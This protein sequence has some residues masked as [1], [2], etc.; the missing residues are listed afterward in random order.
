[1]TD[2][3]LFD[4]DGTLINSEAIILG[5]QMAVAE[6]FGLAFP[7]REAGLAIVG[8]SLPVALE[9]L[10]GTAAPVDA[11]CESYKL[12]FNGMR[13]RAGYEEPPF[14]GVPGLLAELGGWAGATVG[15][16]TGKTRKGVDA[17]VDMHGWHGVFRTIQTADSAPS[18]PDPGMI[19]QAAAET[20]GE[21][22][23]TVMIG[24]SVHDMAMARAAGATA[25]A[26]SWGF[27]PP[28]M[29]EAAGAHL[30][31][32]EVAELPGLIARALRR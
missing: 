7:G 29:L 18:K 24:D 28:A 19:L 21:P 30:V 25:I 16:A 11:L 13:G 14:A 2:L 17:V 10:F 32:R 3:I 8:L 4:L 23:R 5:A 15:M 12:A 31:A 20:G 26:V 6:E 27:Q 9:R 1:M 22:A